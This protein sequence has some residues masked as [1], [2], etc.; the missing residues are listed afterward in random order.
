MLKLK[1]KDQHEEETIPEFEMFLPNLSNNESGGNLTIF[2]KFVAATDRIKIQGFGK[3]TH[4]V[5][6]TVS[7]NV[8]VEKVLRSLE[9]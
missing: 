1:K 4:G 7:L 2:L 8:S 5:Y 9:D 6:M 3:T